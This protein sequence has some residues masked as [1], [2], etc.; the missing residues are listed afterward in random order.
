VAPPPSAARITRKRRRG[1]RRYIGSLPGELT[2]E[3]IRCARLP[4]IDRQRAS[5]IGDGFV[6]P[7]QCG[8]CFRA[9]DPGCDE[10][11]AQLDGAR[12]RRNRFVVASGAMKD[13]AEVELEI[14]NVG[15]GGG[16]GA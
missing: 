12:Q 4:R 11:R 8:E 9:H 16:C 3:R 2:R 13:R 15:S 14:G 10:V 5:K 7:A 6:A 1:R